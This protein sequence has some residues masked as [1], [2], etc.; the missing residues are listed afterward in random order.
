MEKQNK[1]ASQSPQSQPEISVSDRLLAGNSPEDTNI[2]NKQAELEKRVDYVLICLII[3]GTTL[4]GIG[5]QLN[6]FVIAQ[7]NGMP[8]VD[9]NGEANNPLATYH[10]ATNET[11]YVFLADR[12]SW[13]GFS[14][15]DI[16]AYLGSVF[17][18][19]VCVYLLVRKQKTAQEIK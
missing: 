18:I 9:W 17:F 2:Q 16:I 1:Q 8:V 15:G 4:T 14:L 19:I 12:Q 11:R 5:T 10:N 3:I 6:L 13:F 7:N